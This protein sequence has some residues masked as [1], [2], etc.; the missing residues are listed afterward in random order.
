MNII[1]NPPTSRCSVS[2]RGRHRSPKRPVR[3]WAHSFPGLFVSVNH[4]ALGV[5]A[6]STYMDEILL[7]LLKLGAPS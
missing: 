7:K 3:R 6:T 1:S 5:L 4:V 2:T